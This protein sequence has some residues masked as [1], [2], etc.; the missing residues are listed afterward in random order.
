MA[1]CGN[2]HVLTVA[3]WFFK[4]VQSGQRMTDCL[5]THSDFWDAATNLQLV[6][7]LRRSEWVFL[8]SKAKGAGLEGWGGVL[9]AIIIIDLN[10][11]MQETKIVEIEKIL[12]LTG[13]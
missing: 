11:L 10:L 8:C 3:V 4:D 13:I 6:L 5:M 9:N 12:F 1:S 7:G 2:V